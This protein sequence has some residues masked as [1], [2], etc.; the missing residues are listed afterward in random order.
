[1]TRTRDGDTVETLRRAGARA[2]YHLLLAGVEGLKAVE[3][4]LDELG[5]PRKDGDHGEEPIRQRIDLE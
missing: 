1:M 5:H 4:I 3:A 2:A